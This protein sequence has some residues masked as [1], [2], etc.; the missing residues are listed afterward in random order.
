MGLTPCISAARFQRPGGCR[1]FHRRH[2]GIDPLCPPFAA[3]VYVA[4]NTILTDPEIPEALELIRQIHRVGADGLIIQDVGLLELDL[5]PIPLIASTQMHNATPEKVKFLE[6]VGFQPGHS[7]A[8]AFPCRNK[9]H[10][11][12]HPY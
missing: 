8:G 11:R 10:S 4:L 9:S 2:R 3:K 5:P 7:G 6:A 12:C 1:K